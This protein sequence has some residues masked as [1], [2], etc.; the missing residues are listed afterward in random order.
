M[1]LKLNQ[2]VFSAKV[3]PKKTIEKLLG[4]HFLDCNEPRITEISRTLA[5]TVTSFCCLREYWAFTW[6]E[7]CKLALEMN[8][9]SV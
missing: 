1:L 3:Y 7:Y 4:V 8:H 2:Q 5:V 9:M 6:L